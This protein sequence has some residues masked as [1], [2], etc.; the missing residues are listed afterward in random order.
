MADEV[1]MPNPPAYVV[2]PMTQ[3]VAN[4]VTDFVLIIKTIFDAEQK[5]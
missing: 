5:V 2:S 3:Q 1:K 4:Q